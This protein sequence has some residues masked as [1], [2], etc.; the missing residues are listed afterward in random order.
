MTSP[1]KTALVFCGVFAAGM[2][3]CFIGAGA[4]RPAA[5]IVGI[6]VMIFASRIVVGLLR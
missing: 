5:L 1:E 2:A 3:L 6:G 4:G